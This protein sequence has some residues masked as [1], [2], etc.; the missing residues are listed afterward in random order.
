VDQLRQLGWVER[1]NLVIETRSAEGRLE[2][3]PDLAADLIHVPVEVI[4]AYGPTA[5]V[6]SAQLTGTIPIVMVLGGD[7][8]SA[9][10][11]GLLGTFARPVRNVTGNTY[12]HATV[13]T[14]SVELLKTVLPKLSRL[15][16]L[17]DK[18]II[19]YQDLLP[20]AEQAAR[21]LSVH[22]QDLDVRSVEDLDSAFEAAKAWSAEG[23]LVFQQVTFF[24]YARVTELAG[25]NRLPAMYG[26]GFPVTD[27][28]GLMAFSPN[29]GSAL[30]QGAEFVDKILRGASPVDLP[31]QDP[32][33]YDFVVNVKTAQALG[34]TFPPDAAA[35]VT[36]WVQ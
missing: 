15:A 6:A 36:Q 28:G 12:D 35:Q 33:Q 16:I 13:M 27:D 22:T 2:R 20:D 26:A 1:E 7:P 32:R 9:A 10:T 29:F 18:S 3:L 4:L 25:Q 17:G 31:V 14:K 30:R 19:N 34:I 21:T 11:G 8:T 5:A 24:D 23:L